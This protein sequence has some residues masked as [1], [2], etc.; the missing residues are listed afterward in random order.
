MKFIPHHTQR[1]KPWKHPHPSRFQ[2]SNPMT[3][4]IRIQN[5]TS[6]FPQIHQRLGPAVFSSILPRH[7]RVALHHRSDGRDSFSASTSLS[8][9][10][11]QALRPS[12][13]LTSRSRFD[14]FLENL[15]QG[16]IFY[17]ES[18]SLPVAVLALDWWIGG[19]RGVRCMGGSGVEGRV[20]RGRLLRRCRRR[21]LTR[22]WRRGPVECP[23]SRGVK[24]LR[25]K[26]RHSVWRRW[27]RRR[28]LTT[29]TTTMI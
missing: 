17:R 16:E 26:L 5:F 3:R 24:M 21:T 7:C 20:A 12:L 1:K 18:S 22:V 27:W 23:P 28:R 11:S 4:K 19:E 25:Q 13:N 10:D 14:F 8:D 6:A 9:P 15:A 2:Q 29:T